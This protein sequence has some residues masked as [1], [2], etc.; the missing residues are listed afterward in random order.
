MNTKDFTIGV[1]TVTAVILLTTVVLLSV[2][3]PRPVEAFAMLNH[4]NGY[5]LY[6]SNIDGA[7]ENICLLNQQA[8]LLNIYRYDINTGR[9]APVQ[10]IPLLQGSAAVQAAPAPTPAAPAEQDAAS[11]TPAPAR[12]AV[13]RRR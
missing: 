12:P 7:L 9:L 1:L 5:T 10:Q 8:G 4:G 3:T 11:A 13:P 2:L 6:T